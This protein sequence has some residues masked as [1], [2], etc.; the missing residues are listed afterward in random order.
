LPREFGAHDKL[1]AEE[2]KSVYIQYINGNLKEF[3]LTYISVAFPS[4]DNY[5]AGIP[6]RQDRWGISWVRI[7]GSIRLVLSKISDGWIPLQNEGP[8]D[9]FVNEL[10]AR[11]DIILLNTR[12]KIDELVSC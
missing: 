7:D 2:R 9:R 5:Q 12:M 4:K 1:L 11:W 6:D 3:A 8:L 10:L